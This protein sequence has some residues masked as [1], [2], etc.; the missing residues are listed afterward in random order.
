[1]TT[2]VRLRAALPLLAIVCTTV[3]AAAD[4]VT[5]STLGWAV[6]GIVSEVARAGDVAFLGG[7]FGSV[8]PAGNRVHGFATFAADAAVPVLPR[9]TVNGRVRAVV[10]LPGGGWIIGGEFSQVNGTAR[11]RLARLLADGSLDTAFSVAA[12][13]VVWAL[14]V[15]GTR[16]YLGGEFT[17]L[18][19]SARNGLAALDAA[20]LTLDATFTPSVTG[21]AAAV[22]TLAVTSSAV[23]AGGAF[24][25]A[26]GDPRDNLVAV[27][28]ATGATVAAF[29]ATASGR[30]SSLAL[31]GAALFAGG[32]FATIGGTARPHLA[33][34][35]A[36]T[37]AVD[38]AFDAAAGA[39]VNSVVVADG[40]VYVGGT[41]SQIGGASRA[42]IARLDPAS[43]AAAA[44]NPGADGEV[45]QLGV[46]GTA[47]IVGGHFRTIGGL[48]R[49]RLAALDTTAATAI[50]LP[51]NP[52][53][54]SS[55]DMVHVDAA[56]HVFAG[57][58]F[59][60]FGAVL[61]QNLAA[62]DLRAGGLLPWNPGADAWVRALDVV[63]NTVY[64]GGDFQTIAGVSRKRIAALDAVTGVA[65]AWTAEASA[66][67]NGLVVVDDV[68]YFVG[69]FTSVKGST[70]RGRGAAV[71]VDDVVRSWDP[72]ADS[73]IEALAVA[74]GRVYLGGLFSMLGAQSHVRLGAVDA[75]SG[76]PDA[77]FAPTV[78]G[79]VYRVDVHGDLVFFG[80][81]FAMVSASTRHNAAAVK[82]A[83][84][85]GDDGALQGW[86]PDVGGPVYD[87]DAF[88]DDVYLSGGFGSVGGASRPGIAMVDALAAGGALRAWKPT[89]VSGGAV[90]VIDTS[91]TAV[92]FGGLLND[93]DGI[94]IGAVLY[95][96]A[97]LTGTPPAP[98]T[99]TA[100][101]RGSQLTLDW[102]APPLGAR[103]TAYVIEGGTGPG[104]ANLAN[105]NTGS[106][107]TEF[108]I[109]G[110][111][112]GTYYVRMRAATGFGVSA[113]TAEQ[114][115]DV[116]VAGCSGPPVPPVDVAAAVSGGTVQLT[117][118]AAPQSIVTNYRLL[119]GTTSGGSQVGSFDVGAGT[120][121]SAAA[122]PGAFFIRVAAMN[123]CGLGAPSAEAV[124][125]VGAPVVP[126]TAPFGLDYTVAGSTVS[127]AWGAPSIGTGPFQYQ[128]EAGSATGL[129]NI[130]TVPVATTTFAVPGVPPGIYYVRVRAVGAG[131]AS[132]AS[133]EVVVVVP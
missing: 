113:A 64:I 76:A 95:P 100:L 96:E 69:A 66:P 4:P 47:L 68:V 71:G 82:A 17:S 24:T 25:T 46:F 90:S 13:D 120:T 62:I 127:F 78:D 84:G 123:G 91:A 117:W 20:A 73:E 27:D 23:Y 106:T 1:M 57:G 118:R 21:G 51:W 56:G 133:N 14:A 104:L 28:I 34:L 10:A 99:P 7:S 109:G 108:A 80:G 63:G 49:L 50:T 89:D 112:P 54:S 26:N 61:R 60:H 81:D 29:T 9:L 37:G 94:S 88:D 130:A 15:H 30:V 44:W 6:N 105:F 42:R 125:V 114:A 53:L 102:G 119:V 11:S 85:A 41:F 48:E 52:A 92:L 70:A 79:P 39:V 128:L 122:P 2:H 111:G 87:L 132:P 75:V 121:F 36:T 86:N 98:T 115:F 22:Y 3:P 35:D 55:V 77:G 116:G 12:N 72:A 83:P 33:R 16:V 101:V 74:G 107:A 59:T 65:R 40:A 18:G 126:P 8:A 5:T 32:E 110:L 31:S 45:E 97:G 43:G 124:A 38:T 103:P 93:L 67:V 131:G 58:S 129:A 19:G